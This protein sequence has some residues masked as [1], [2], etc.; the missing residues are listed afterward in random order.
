MKTFIKFIF[1]ITFISIVK[2]VSAQASADFFGVVPKAYSNW[3]RGG[4]GMNI[5]SAAINSTNVKG[6]NYVECRL[7]GGFYFSGLSQK[8]VS[9][10]PLTAPQTGNAS[11]T[12]SNRVHGLNGIIRFSLP[13][14][15]KIVPYCDVFAGMRGFTSNMNIIPGSTQNGCNTCNTSTSQ[16]LSTVSEFNYGATGGI[17]VSLGKSVKLNLGLSYSESNHIGKI[18]NIDTAHLQSGTIELDQMY[19]PSSML[20]ATF[21]LTFCFD[22]SWSGGPSGNYSNSYSPSYN[23]YS[24]PSSYSGSHCTGGGNSGV[25]VHISSGRVK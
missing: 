8:D 16:N 4:F 6:A 22:G 3:G 10:V 5:L 1:A 12:L 15:N 9:N 11:V 19:A 24:H 23:N 7:G 17:L 18:I 13:Y 2:N 21:G 14:S 20:L 25:S